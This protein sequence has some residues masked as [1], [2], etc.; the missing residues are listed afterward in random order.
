VTTRTC[1]NAALFYCLNNDMAPPAIL[2]TSLNKGALGQ[3]FPLSGYMAY[4]AETPP[5]ARGRESMVKKKTDMDSTSFIIA[6]SDFR[7][8]MCQK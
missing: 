6:R 4:C 1:A 5:P 2:P 3:C 7:Y 8:K